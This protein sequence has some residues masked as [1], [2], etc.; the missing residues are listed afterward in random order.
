MQK[1][2]LRFL[3]PL[4]FLMNLIVGSLGCDTFSQASVAFSG[5]HVSFAESS[6]Q[7][8]LAGNTLSIMVIPDTGY[9]LT[10]SVSGNCPAGSWSGNV[11]TTGVILADCSLLFSATSNPQTIT[12]SGEHV[13]IDPSDVQ[14]VAYNDTFSFSVAAEASYTLSNV[15]DGTCA[16]GTWAGALYTTGPVTED[17]TVIFSASEDAYTLGGSVSGLIGSGLVLRNNGGDDLPLNSDGGFTFST[18]LAVGATYLVTVQSQP[19]GQ[20]CTV[21][22]DS[23]TM[24]ESDVTDVTVTCALNAYTVGGTVSGLSGTVVLQNNSSDSLP[25]SADGA[26]TFSTPVAEGASYNVTVQTQPTLQ[27]CSVTNGSGTMG[28]SNVTNVLVTCVTNTTSLTISQSELALS[29]TGF[30]EYGVSG[31]PA[32]GVARTLTIMNAGSFLASNLSVNFPTWPTGTIATSDCGS[33]LASGSSCTLTITPGNTASS[34][35]VSPCTTAGS[36]PVA[37]NI[38]ISAD[39]ANSLSADV[40]ILGYACIYNGGYVYALDDSTASDTSVGGKV[41]TSS[42]QSAGI[43]WSSNSSGTYDGGVAIYGISQTSTI[44]SPNPSSGQVA[45][46]TACNGAID[47]A[48]NSNNIYVYYQT[49]AT[50]APISTSFYAAGLCKQTISGYSDWY[51]PAICELG[52]DATSFGS[53]CGS[54]STPT[55]QNMQS[56]LVDFNALNLLSG[57]YWSSTESFAT[58]QT[59]ALRQFFA[60]SSSQGN[61]GKNGSRLVRC[62]REF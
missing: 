43:I 22:N 36:A 25:L 35:G 30:T 34:D 38:S 39:N 28:A 33:T 1:I 21:N 4:F 41:V 55:L 37:S 16:A 47:G 48:C 60:A 6:P 24:G 31:T 46:Q 44:S 10:T 50:G 8:V 40:L 19:S 54:V 53:G 56:N 42:D 3:L 52:Y 58:P 61:S 59:N 12:P 27:T 17:C 11:Y 14:I 57:L 13:I 45:G 29:I 49:V 32:S 9:T 2:C 15:V 23:G 20:T 62:A 26:F 51:L 7:E 5:T 18:P